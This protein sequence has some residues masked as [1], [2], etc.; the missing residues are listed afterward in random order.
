MNHL[1]CRTFGSRP[2]LIRDVVMMMAEI[3]Q[4][5]FPPVFRARTQAKHSSQLLL[6]LSSRPGS[7]IIS[8]FGIFGQFYMDAQSYPKTCW[9]RR[10]RRLLFKNSKNNNNKQNRTPCSLQSHSFPPAAATTCTRSET[11]QQRGIGWRAGQRWSS[12]TT[13]GIDWTHRN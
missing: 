8:W 6:S 7:N 12:E 2:S 1:Y 9:R 5:L 10:R 3:E 11:G 13:T 4:V